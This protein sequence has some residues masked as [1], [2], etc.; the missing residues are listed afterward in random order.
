MIQKYGYTALKMGIQA[1]A[2]EPFNKATRDS[3]AA[4]QGIAHTIEAAVVDE[5]A[6][7]L[8]AQQALADA[9]S[10][11]MARGNPRPS[12]RTNSKPSAPFTIANPSRCN[13]P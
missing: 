2:D 13:S 11:A 4:I 3:V 5:G 1:D 7:E 10:D 6:E 8:Q 9:Q 12:G